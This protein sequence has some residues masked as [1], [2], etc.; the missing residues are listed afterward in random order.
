MSLLVV[1]DHPDRLNPGTDTTIPIIDAVKRRKPVWICR[2]EQLE[3]EG[4]RLFVTAAEVT[5]ARPALQ[6]DGEQRRPV[7]EFGAVFMRK[8][9]PFDL[10]YYFATLLL[11]R[12]RGKAFLL[13][14]PR[15]LR[16]AN[17]K[18]Y[19]FQFPSLIAPTCVSRSMDRLRAFLTEQGGEMIVKP[20]DLCGGMSVF[21]VRADDRNT[22]V[23]LETMSQNGRKLVM[24]QKYLPA[25]RQGDKRILLL[26]GEP[27]GAVMRVPRANETRGNLHAGGRAEKT[28]LNAREQQI[29]KEV[30]ARCRADGLY[31]VGIDV[32]GDCL[33]EVNVT[34]PTGV[35]E[36]DR[37]DG[38]QL[39]EKIA[40]FIV[41]KMI[42]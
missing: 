25:A 32:I 42:G 8:D 11:E 13:N 20:L 27:I 38:V 17:E 12:A 29:C 35:Q 21:H 6:W 40:D 36:I 1:M 41:A 28:T 5:Q 9:P 31:F 26:D 24:A 34:S 22:N 19:I 18:L 39:E 7:D 4:D 16:D 33:T 10:D 23:I 15:G 3:L 14:D 30:G 2:P 37:L